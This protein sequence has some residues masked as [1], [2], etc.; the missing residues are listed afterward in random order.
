ME[1]EFKIIETALNRLHDI[2]LSHLDSFDK[3]GL[4]DL[5]KQSEERNIEI[6][7]LL[8][9]INEFVE[10]ANEKQGASAETMLS[11]LSDKVTILLEQNKVLEI[12]VLAFKDGLKKGMKQISKGNQA[13]SSYK[14][15]NSVLNNPKVVSVTN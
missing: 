4:P 8:K 12:K 13:I 2:Q 7:K 10:L 11:F 9:G 14:S 15:S 5:E 6:D 1:N 3:K